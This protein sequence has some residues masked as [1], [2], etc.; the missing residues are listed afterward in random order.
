MEE[1]L[2]SASFEGE[3]EFILPEGAKITQKDVNISVRQIKNGFILRK[4]YDIKY[5]YEGETKYD[6]FSVEL[7]SKTNPLTINIK[8]KSLSD[9]LDD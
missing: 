6:Y 3:R 5:L 1:A 9:K 2:K 7:Y 4:S 8:D